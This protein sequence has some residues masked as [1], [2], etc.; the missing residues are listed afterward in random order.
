MGRAIHPIPNGDVRSLAHL[1]QQSSVLASKE[2]GHPQCGCPA[3]PD[4]RGDVRVRAAGLMM[5][6]SITYATGPR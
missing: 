3:P 6:C 2:I 4:E 5:N 1:C